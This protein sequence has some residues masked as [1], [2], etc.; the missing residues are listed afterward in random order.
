[1]AL[2]HTT[3][4]DLDESTLIKTEGEL[5]ND[6]ELTRWVEYRQTEDGEVIHRSVH[7]HLK[8]GL[9]LASAVGGF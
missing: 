6:H 9:S 3:L 5:D 4:G 7:V 8:Q 1:M 2:I